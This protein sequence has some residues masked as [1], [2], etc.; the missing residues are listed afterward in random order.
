MFLASPSMFQDRAQN[1]LYCI[2]F[3]F[4][5]ES[6]VSAPSADL[7]EASTSTVSV[8]LLEASTSTVDLSKAASLKRPE[9]LGYHH[10]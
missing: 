4:K 8:E 5:S 1:V 3:V 7:S 9:G 6:E 2:G 10:S